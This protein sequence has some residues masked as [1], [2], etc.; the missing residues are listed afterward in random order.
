FLAG[1]MHEYVRIGQSVG[2]FT[3]LDLSFDPTRNFTLWT[4]LV[5][6]TVF[7][8]ASHGADQMMVQRY[9]CSRSLGQARAALVL[10]GVIVLIQFLLF[11]L[12]GVGLYVLAQQGLLTGGASLKN[13]EVFGHFIVTALPHGLVGLV[14]AAVLAASMSTLSSSLSSGASAFVADFYHPLLPGRSDGHYL[15]VSRIMTG[16]WGLTRILVALLALSLLSTRSIINEVLRVAG[17]TTGMVLGLFLLGLMRRPV[18]SSA[19]LTGLVAGFLIVGAIW[20]TTSLAWPWY[21]PIGTLTTV[22]VALFF[23][24]SRRVHR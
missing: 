5:G 12:L 6:G 3:L 14:I 24:V 9:L 7:T 23:E 22:V 16:V 17:F 2:K 8:M 11:L 10:S 20:S 21:A 4:G 15:L 19:A 1:G 18:S 13:D